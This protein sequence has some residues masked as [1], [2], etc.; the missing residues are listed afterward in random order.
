MTS[1]LLGVLHCFWIETVAVIAKFD[2]Q[3][4]SGEIDAH[5]HRSG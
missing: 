5:R 2:A 1:W 4:V 3:L